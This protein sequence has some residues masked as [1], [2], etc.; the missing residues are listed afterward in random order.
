MSRGFIKYLRV[1]WPDVRQGRSGLTGWRSRF[2]GSCPAAFRGGYHTDEYGIQPAAPAVRLV[3]A[4]AGIHGI[5]TVM[6]A[7][8]IST[9]HG[10]R[11]VSSYYYIRQISNSYKISPE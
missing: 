1:K 7:F 4:L 10:A 2:A 8:I 9:N 11:P 6:F 5:V 3:I